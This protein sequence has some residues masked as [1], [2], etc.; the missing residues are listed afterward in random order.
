MDGLIDEFLAD[1]LG[2]LALYFSFAGGLGRLYLFLL[3]ASRLSGLLLVSPT[4]CAISLPWIVRITLVIL[5][6]LVVTPALATNAHLEFGIVQ[7]SDSSRSEA[8]PENLVGLSIAILREMGLGTLFGIGLIAIFSGLKLGAEWIERHTGLA[9][10]STLN[11]DWQG[12]GRVTQSLVLY[13]G[14]AGLL[15]IEPLGSDWHLIRILLQSF[16]SVPVGSSTWTVSSFELVN[17]AIQQSL[18]LGIRVAMPIVAT[19]MLVDTAIAFASRGTSS[20][21]TTA[22]LAVRSFVGLIV[23]A[24]TATGIPEAV[25]QSMVAAIRLVTEF[26][27]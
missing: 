8:I 3:V 16:R 15:L 9:V 1:P 10:A 27:L 17:S 20:A 12:S 5:L 19:M 21:E 26:A 22:L 14:L 2:R 18:L 4:L 13:F 24:L 25:F 6:S 7:V 23:L 11:P